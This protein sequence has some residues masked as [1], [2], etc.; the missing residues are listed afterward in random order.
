MRTNLDS[1]SGHEPDYLPPDAK[2]E[3]GYIRYI[4]LLPKERIDGEIYFE[5][6]IRRYQPDYDEDRF[7]PPESFS[8]TAISYS[9]GDPAL[10]HSIDVDGHERPVATNLWHFLQRASIQCGDSRRV[11]LHRVRN[12]RFERARWVQAQG[13][14]AYRLLENTMRTSLEK[15][16][17]FCSNENW[18]DWEFEEPKPTT[19]LEFTHRIEDE[20]VRDEFRDPKVTEYLEFKHR[21]DNLMAEQKKWYE[22]WL[23]I[24]ALCIDQ[25]DARERTHQVGIMSEIFGRADQVISWLGPAYDNSEHAMTTIA[26]YTSDENS[27]VVHALGQAEL[28]EAICSLCERLYWKRLW[29]FQELRHAK[30]IVLMCGAETISW[31]HFQ[32]LWRVIVEI[33]TTD[34]SRSDRL[35]QSLA[36][37]MM[38]LR[39]KPMNFSLWNLLKETQNLE[40]ADQRDRIYALLSVATEGRE[41]IEA[42]YGPAV[43]PLRLAH[44]IMHIKH[45]MRQPRMLNAVM[46]ECRFLEDVFRLTQGAMLWYHSDVN[47]NRDWWYKYDGGGH[48]S[49]QYQALDPVVDFSR[50]DPEN[51]QVNSSWSA[52]AHFHGHT[53][54]TKLLED[55]R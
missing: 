50:V 28:S 20:M 51:P 45:A 41:G 13:R 33:A 6:C 29:V 36:T 15:V 11:R 30:S 35:K 42:D 47:Y 34:E 27:N 8:Y 38:T 46:T 4:R 55:G 39:S 19:Y 37:R 3:A 18:R 9:W 1:G 2:L 14:M 54:V 49:E 26:G 48:V 17:S 52:W 24:D 25:S 32:L 7:P 23:W 12:L 10:S 53:A 5:T 21:I 31:H 40:C 43:T 44:R 22:G 16:E